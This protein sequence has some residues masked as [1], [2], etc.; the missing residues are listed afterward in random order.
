MGDKAGQHVV[1][2]GDKSGQCVVQAAV[3]EELL[4]SLLI[5]GRRLGN[6]GDKAGQ[7]VVTARVTGKYRWDT[8]YKTIYICDS[9]Y[10]TTC[11]TSYNT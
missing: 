1:I 8:T 3:V 9:D 4:Q 6:R 5:L 10:D 7:R 11:F 2:G